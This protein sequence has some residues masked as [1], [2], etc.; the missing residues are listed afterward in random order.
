MFNIAHVKQTFRFYLRVWK[1][2]EIM[3]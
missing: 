2:R 3:I 1:V